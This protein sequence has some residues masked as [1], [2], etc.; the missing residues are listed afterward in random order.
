MQYFYAFLEE[1]REKKDEEVY[2][3][4][5]TFDKLKYYTVPE[6]HKRL[7]QHPLIKSSMIVH[8]GWHKKH[9]AACLNNN[10]CIPPRLL[11]HHPHDAHKIDILSNHKILWPSYSFS[12][13][14]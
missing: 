6:A 4:K 11:G 7:E 3:K 14:D 10:L 2:F 8:D 9:T 5:L 12:F 13:H 1:N